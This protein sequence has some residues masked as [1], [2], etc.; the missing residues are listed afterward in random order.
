MTKHQLWKLAAAVA[1]A[2]MLVVPGVSASTSVFQ[3]PPPVPPPNDN[4]AS[5]T[6][7]SSVPFSD[8]VD[9]G[10]ATT[11]YGEPQWCYWAYQTI[12]YRYTPDANGLVR[13]TLSGIYD[14]NLVIYQAYGPNMTK[15]ES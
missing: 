4:F 3:S 5:A 10:M 12:W 11:E 1:L 13:V 9:I 8:A 6:I 14:S 2:T 15:F 7:I